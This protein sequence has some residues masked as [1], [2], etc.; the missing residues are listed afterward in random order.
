MAKAGSNRSFEITAAVGETTPRQQQQQQQQ[1]RRRSLGEGNAMQRRENRRSMNKKAGSTRSFD[2][3]IGEAHP[4]N[5][6][7]TTRQ[8]RERRRSLDLKK[9]NS[10]RSFE[11]PTSSGRQPRRNSLG[12]EKAMYRAES[13]RNM[14]EALKVLERANNSDRGNNNIQRIISTSEEEEERTDNIPTE[15]VIFPE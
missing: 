1:Q 4:M 7:T 6:S 2:V 15:I 3:S 12:N 11:N 5:G 13:K 9:A 14:G 8:K 10:N